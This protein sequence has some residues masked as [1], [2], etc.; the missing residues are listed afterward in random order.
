M[1]SEEIALRDA[2]VKLQSLNE[3][4]GQDKIELNKIIKQMESEKSSLS[5]DKRDLE[6]EKNSI[7]Q[8][9]IRVEQEKVRKG[10]QMV[11]SGINF[12][13]VLFC[14]VLPLG[15]GNYKILTRC[16]WSHFLISRVYHFIKPLIS[17]V[18][19]QIAL[20]IVGF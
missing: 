6:N 14:F 5:Q 15:E 2:L 8:E 4:L 7:R 13:H 10:N 3:G 12:T 17:I 18:L 16:E 1:K 9:L 20:R 11:T 19:R